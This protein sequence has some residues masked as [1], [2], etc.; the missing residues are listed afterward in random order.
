MADVIELFPHRQFTDA[1][2]S[3]LCAA[4]IKRAWQIYFVHYNDRREQALIYRVTG[5]SEPEW[6][7]DKSRGLWTARDREGSKV[8]AA[9]GPTELIDALAGDLVA[10][11]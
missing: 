9:T 2:L 11:R 3:A 7:I 5:E 8:A 6:V 10:V 1:E 4:V